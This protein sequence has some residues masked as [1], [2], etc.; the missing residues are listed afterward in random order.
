MSASP[1]T[2]H[3]WHSPQTAGALARNLTNNFY[4][5]VYAHFGLIW[6]DTLPKEVLATLIANDQYPETTA[7]PDNEF[8]QRKIKPA[9]EFLL[10]ILRQ[11]LMDQ[12]LQEGCLVEVD[13]RGAAAKQSWH[14]SLASK[15]RKAQDELKLQ[16]PAAMSIQKALSQHPTA[17]P[18][19]INRLSSILFMIKSDSDTPDLLESSP[20]QAAGS[21]AD[22][23]DF[24]S[25]VEESSGAARTTLGSPLLLATPLL[26]PSLERPAEDESDNDTDDS[27]IISPQHP[28]ESPF[29]EQSGHRAYPHSPSTAPTTPF[30]SPSSARGASH[31][32]TANDSRQV[33]VSPATPDAPTII[34]TVPTGSTDGQPEEGNNPAVEES[35]GTETPAPAVPDA[36]Q[37]HT[38]DAKD[39]R[40][41]TDPQVQPRENGPKSRDPYKT[42]ER[43]SASLPSIRSQ[44]AGQQQQGAQPAMS[45]KANANKSSSSG[46]RS[47]RSSSVA[48]PTSTRSSPGSPLHDLPHIPRS[49]KTVPRKSVPPTTP[50]KETPNPPSLKIEIPSTPSRSRSSTGRQTSTEATPLTA[51]SSRGSSRKFPSDITN[52]TDAST[53]SSSTESGGDW[54]ELSM[55][56]RGAP[57]LPER[58]SN[59]DRISAKTP[60]WKGKNPG[61]SALQRDSRD[62]SAARHESHS[63]ERPISVTK[64]DQSPR[65]RTHSLGSGTRVWVDAPELESNNQG[66]LRSAGLAFENQHYERIS[67]VV[68]D[69][70]KTAR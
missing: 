25:P 10:P 19:M 38:E 16:N 56:S 66:F 44:T 11:L 20:G 41:R 31:G 57:S 35:K 67:V 54:D 68:V 49:F 69:I 70:R 47:P 52:R 27:S 6:P 4:Y 59:K 50:L 15:L 9:I 37:N 24:T 22:L 7:I 29:T 28:L 30:K 26:H 42:P 21:S 40:Q 62:S 1:L 5:T 64:R 36:E 2:P 3:L 48:A 13:A 43:R 60:V 23:I 34:L 8:I 14:L 12:E 17:L 63:R 51:V 32:K 45:P 18:Q 33:L 58:R 55:S 53:E 61:W 46:T 65:R 39:D